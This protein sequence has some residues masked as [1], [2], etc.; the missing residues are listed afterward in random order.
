MLRDG[1][2]Q[3]RMPSRKTLLVLLAGGIV[4]A[5]LLALNAPTTRKGPPLATSCT[6]P[7]MALSSQVT[8]DGSNLEYSITGPPSG[9]YV[10]AVDAETVTVE[11]DGVTATPKGAF[12]TTARRGLKGCAANGS[13]PTLSAGPHEVVLF[14]DGQ[15]VARARLAD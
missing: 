6:T 14:R 8:G 5:V 2:H 1:A 10:V 3:P 11:G 9:T 7:A 4:L 13:L 15:A 12:A